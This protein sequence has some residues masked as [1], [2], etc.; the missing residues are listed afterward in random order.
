MTTPRISVR[1]LKAR[2]RLGCTP[3]ER[4]YPQTVVVD[5]VLRLTPAAMVSTTSD[6]L[7][8]TVD[9]MAVAA[10]VE[11]T[12]R[13]GEWRLLEK[14]CRDIGVAVRQLSPLVR[15]VDVA[16]RKNVLPH[17]DGVVCELTVE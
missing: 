8:D 5:L 16:V 2:A 7:G 1:A 10:V 9:Y 14:M 4:A 15:S 17:A 3:E 12:C 13:D 11:A 6:E